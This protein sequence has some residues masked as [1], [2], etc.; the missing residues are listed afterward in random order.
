MDSVPSILISRWHPWHG[1]Y[2]SAGSLPNVIVALAKL[3]L[4]AQEEDE[5][6]DSKL[7]KTI[8]DALGMD[9]D[10]FKGAIQGMNADAFSSDA[11]KQA[12]AKAKLDEYFERA[13]K[14]EDE[15]VRA[16]AT[17]NL[18]NGWS[19]LTPARVPFCGGG[20]CF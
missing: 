20:D 19:R 14:I 10:A 3:G 1:T 7:Q 2:A 17:Q 15:E 8:A 5:D 12:E 18:D 16:S 9:A 11:A 6:A 4:A 13:K